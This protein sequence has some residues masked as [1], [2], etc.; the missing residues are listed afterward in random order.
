MSQTVSAFLGLVAIAIDF[1]SFGAAP[2]IQTEVREAPAVVRARAVLELA[3]EEREPNP[4]DVLQ[5]Q[6]GLAHALIAE[7]RFEDAEI[8]LNEMRPAV[9]RSY[10]PDSRQ[11]IGFNSWLA[12]VLAAE[13]E[14]LAA[15]EVSQ[16]NYKRALQQFGPANADTHRL[17]VVMGAAL[18]QRGRFSEAEPL[19]RASFDYLLETEGAQGGASQIASTL[20][21]LYAS[22]ERPEDAT[23]V[24]ALVQGDETDRLAG[25]IL[26][27]QMRGGNES[28]IGLAQD[29]LADPDLDV[30]TRTTVENDLLVAMT[31]VARAGTDDD[32]RS[33][34]ALAR[35]IVD[36]RPVTAPGSAFASNALGDILLLGHELRTPSRLAEGLTMKE[37]ALHDF[38]Q[39]LGHD[40]PLTVAQRLSLA[41]AYNDQGD[42]GA[43][44]ETLAAFDS[45]PGALSDDL[46]R[47]VASMRA[48]ARDLSNGA[49]RSRS[50]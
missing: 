2:F 31:A 12:T 48:D 22:L 16:Q 32:V 49:L 42:G 11:M 13:Q 25:A 4:T 20:A 37:V 9:L 50:D 21:R 41:Q 39:T 33:A 34:E 18:M 46:E 47:R 3:R 14:W 36:T 44:F 28:V 5:S 30:A 23:H 35:E 24:L 27:A 29:L 43:A 38:E 10:A 6:W 40:H 19:M 1:L 15:E 8:V 26:A 17:R 7:R 45:A